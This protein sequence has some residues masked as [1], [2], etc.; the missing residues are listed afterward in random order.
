MLFW[1][2]R[3][4]NPALSHSFVQKVYPLTSE[5]MNSDFR[6]ISNVVDVVVVVFAAI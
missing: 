6:R 2:L 5:W 1:Y 3:P 4:G